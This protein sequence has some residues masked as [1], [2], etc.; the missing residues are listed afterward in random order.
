MMPTITNSS[1]IALN[2]IVG[3]DPSQIYGHLNANGQVFL[4][5]P[6]G[7]LFAPGS[8]VN[9]SGLVASTFWLADADFVA[10]QFRFSGVT[11]NVVNQGNLTAAEGGYIA[12]LGGQ[13]SNQG[14]IVAKLGTVDLV[15]GSEVTLDFA[16]DGL[17]SV[18]VNQGAVDALAE[19]KQ[20]IRA[21]GGQVLLT[22]KAADALASAVVNN[23][24]VIEARTLSNRAGSG[25]RHG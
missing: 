22:A 8:Q 19:N 3:S 6:N 5:N 23:S 13:V 11:G 12:L 21:D 18:Q 10:D 2:R 25:S 20:L 7:V 4:L 9:V 16:G 15:A 14:T 1:A 17:L 24:G